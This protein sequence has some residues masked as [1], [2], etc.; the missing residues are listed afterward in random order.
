MP[1]LTV[2]KENVIWGGSHYS[3]SLTAPAHSFMG[4]SSGW[5]VGTVT[6]T[7]YSALVYNTEVSRTT[8]TATTPI[9]TLNSESVAGNAI[10]VGGP[11]TGSFTS[12]IWQITQSVKA[13][14]NGGDQ[15]GNFH[16]LIFRGSDPTGSNAT[17]ISSTYGT[18]SS[19]TNLTTDTS[20]TL[21]TSYNLPQ[22]NCNNEYL[23]LAVQWSITGA[24][25]A[26]GCDVDLFVG[27][28]TQSVFTTTNFTVVTSSF[29]DNIIIRSSF[30][31]GIY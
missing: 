12:G 23:F 1:L 21:L 25:G 29:V 7:K 6:P 19:A 18:S 24:G 14:T 13:N 22:I 15:G 28:T 20:Q 2:Y 17:Q 16:Y 8:I 9:A 11:F 3:S 4:N 5:N 26:V 30:G 31:I 27:P 10:L